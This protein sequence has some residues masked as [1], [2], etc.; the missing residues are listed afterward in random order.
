M[1]IYDITKRMAMAVASWFRRWGRNSARRASMAGKHDMILTINAQVTVDLSAF[2]KGPGTICN[3]TL[4]YNGLGQP[5][6]VRF[7]ID[8]IPAEIV[9]AVLNNGLGSKLEG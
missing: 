7:V 4:T 1:K 9:N 5:D 6:F 8:A 3:G 2:G